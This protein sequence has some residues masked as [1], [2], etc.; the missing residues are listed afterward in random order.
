VYL[1]IPSLRVTGN[2]CKVLYIC[3]RGSKWIDV[4]IYCLFHNAAMTILREIIQGVPL[5]LLLSTAVFAGCPSG[6]GLPMR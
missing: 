5:I 3:K 2:V 6:L 4:F 1:N